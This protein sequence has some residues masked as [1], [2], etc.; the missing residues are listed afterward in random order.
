MEILHIYYGTDSEGRL[1]IT[2]AIPEDLAEAGANFLLERSRTMRNPDYVLM[3]EAVKYGLEVQVETPVAEEV[4]T[5]PASRPSPAKKKVEVTQPVIKE[6]D[7]TPKMETPDIKS[8]EEIEESN[9]LF[10][11]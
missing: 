6:E 10:N 7:E 1:I 5:K 11:D 9:T 2:K 8:K 3:E 4:A